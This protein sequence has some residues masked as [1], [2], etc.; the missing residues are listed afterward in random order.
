MDGYANK[1]DI[2]Q[3]KHS[4]LDVDGSP[5]DFGLGEKVVYSLTADFKK[6]LSSIL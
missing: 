2:Y 5:D 1:F 4:L 6:K 3:G